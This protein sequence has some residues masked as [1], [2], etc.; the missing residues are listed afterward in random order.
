MRVAL[1]NTRTT[2]HLMLRFDP[3]RPPPRRASSRPEEIAL[4]ADPHDQLEHN[5]TN[6]PPVDDSIV[7]RFEVI[8]DE[9]KVLGRQILNSCPESRERSLAL[10]NLEQTVMWAVA[11]IARNQEKLAA[12][13]E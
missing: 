9:A 3:L 11:S 2:V 5:L 6:H 4:P 7:K 10:T 8:R 13:A 1:D 12:P